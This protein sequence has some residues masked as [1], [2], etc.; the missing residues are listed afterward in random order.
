GPRHAAG[1]DRG[2]RTRRGG[3]G[4]R[5][6]APIVPVPAM[7]RGLL[8]AAAAVAAA[9][10]LAANTSRIYDPDVWQHVGVGQVI[11][12]T[13]AIPHTQLWTWP[14]H[15]SPDVLP[16]WLFRVALWPFWRVGGLWGFYAWRWLTTLL[17]FGLAWLAARRMGA[18][19]AAPLAVLVWCALL[20]RG[21]S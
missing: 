6:E 11:W 3:S 13:H 1:D 10:A 19:G 8:V 5:T 7:P 2:G 21:R 15:G 4:A 18:T 14:T 16:S 20:W 9:C 12:Q 17:A